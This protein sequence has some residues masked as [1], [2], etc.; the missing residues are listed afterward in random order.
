[1]VM[2]PECASLLPGY[3]CFDRATEVEEER[4]IDDE[5]VDFTHRDPVRVA[6]KF[7]EVHCHQTC[8]LTLELT[9]ALYRVRVERLVI[10]HITSAR[11]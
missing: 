8:A 1:M 3:A 7:E 11:F 9:G 5:R 2:F 6:V 10:W 4:A